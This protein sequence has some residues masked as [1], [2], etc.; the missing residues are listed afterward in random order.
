MSGLPVLKIMGM[1]ATALT[2]FFLDEGAL[3]ACPSQT[4][5]ERFGEEAHLL[6]REEHEIEIGDLEH[7]EGIFLT[8]P[9]DKMSPV[10]AALRGKF[11][12]LVF[13]WQG[14]DITAEFPIVSKSMLD[15]LRHRV[16]P[17]VPGHHHLK[18]FASALLDLLEKKELAGHPEKREAIGCNLAARLVWDSCQP[19]REVRIEHVKLDGRVISLR[20]GRILAA[21]ARQGRL[22][23]KREGFKPG[24]DS[25]VS[26]RERRQAIMTS[27]NFTAAA[28]IT[29][30][31]IFAN[32]AV[33]WAPT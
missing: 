6:V 18:N 24:G 14:D 31:S 28:G 30:I 17:T 29:A 15:G 2:R 26:R 3:I 20:P 10:I 4:V 5:A 8:G 27:A 16:V 25:T 22:L 13:R 19:G 7:S 21:D 11:W 32:R 9:D 23:L 12:D 1:Y 33:H